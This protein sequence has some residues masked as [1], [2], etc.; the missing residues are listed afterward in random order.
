M[1]DKQPDFILYITDQ[2]S[3]DFLV[4]YGHPLVQTPHI[5][6]MAAQGLSFD[7]FYVASPD[8]MPNRQPDDRASAI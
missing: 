7:R 5:D 2:H 3:A 6:A 4:C 8:C 1:S